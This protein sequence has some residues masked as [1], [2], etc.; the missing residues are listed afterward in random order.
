MDKTRLVVVFDDEESKEDIDLLIHSVDET[1]LILKE[2]FDDGNK[3][4]IEVSS[5]IP[6]PDFKGNLEEYWMSVL[7]DSKCP[8]CSPV[9]DTQI[10]VWDVI[11]LTVFIKRDLELNANIGGIYKDIWSKY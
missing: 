11:R 3:M 8:C 9:E 1:G 2:I 10:V 4:I 6:D 7:N 5:E